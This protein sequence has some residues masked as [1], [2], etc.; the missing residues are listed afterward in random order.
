MR[1]WRQTHVSVHPH[2]RG[3]D[4]ILAFPVSSYRGSPPRAW[5]R[6]RDRNVHPHFY[7]FTPTC[8]GTTTPCDA[9]IAASPV[10]PHVR[11]DDVSRAGST[12]AR[13][14]SPPRAW[15]RR[16]EVTEPKLGP[17]FTP[18]CVGTTTGASSMVSVASVHPHVR[19]D[20]SGPAHTTTGSPGSPPR[21]WGRRRKA[22]HHGQ[23]RRFTPTCV[24][25]TRDKGA[26]TRRSTVHPHVRGD[27]L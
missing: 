16:L 24:G 27:D 4:S 11:G 21:A 9:I 13:G 1:F 2:V 3:D 19:G 15:G 26:S 6:L 14:G 5:G 10:H 8:V 18:T 23:L 20:D 22:R 25:T 7:R 17:R 12:S